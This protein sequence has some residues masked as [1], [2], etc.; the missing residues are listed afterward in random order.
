VLEVCWFAL[1]SKR[2]CQITFVFKVSLGIPRY[3]MVVEGNL[4]PQIIDSIKFLFSE[5][6]Q[7]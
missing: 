5:S 2:L 4:L 6:V 3:Y 1:F 7:I